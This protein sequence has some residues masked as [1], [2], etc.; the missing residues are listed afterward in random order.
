MNTQINQR[1]IFVQTSRIGFNLTGVSLLTLDEIKALA[2][3][4][5]ALDTTASFSAKI[6][7]DNDVVIG[8]INSSPEV[9]GTA[10]NRM[11]VCTVNLA[12]GLG[13]SCATNATIGIGDYLLGAG[14]GLVKGGGTSGFLVTDDSTISQGFVTA[15]KF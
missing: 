12:G 1:G 6:A 5:V 8:T 3:K 11:V 13:F 15:I 4:A 9:T 2:G 14:D 7:E 10:A